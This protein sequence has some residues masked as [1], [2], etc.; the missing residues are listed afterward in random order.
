MNPRARFDAAFYQRYYRNRRT[1][2]VSA[3]QTRRRAQKLIAGARDLQ[4]PIRRILDAG[5]GL[6]TL[7]APLLRAFP[8]A[9][10]T[11]LEVSEYLCRRYGW[12]NESLAAYKPKV[13][14]DLLICQ[15]VLQYLPDGEARRAMANLAR[16]C[17]G[18][19]YFNVP[20][21]EDWRGI[22]DPKGSDG[23]IILR[24]AA[25]YRDRLRRHFR[26]LGQGLLIHRSW[27]VPQWE[28]ERPWE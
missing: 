8:G 20:T 17:A 1:R 4:I 18:L 21:L 23:Q 6:G 7:R 9:K 25:W 27:E 3:E 14:F 10:Y 28:M 22:A 11:G 24:H 12:I 15:D 2:I 16:L 5:C 26:H 13:Q 19:V